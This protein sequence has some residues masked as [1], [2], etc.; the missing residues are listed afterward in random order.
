VQHCPLV[1]VVENNGYAYSTPTRKQ[2]LAAS[3]VDKAIGYGIAAEQADG[4]DVIATYVATKRAVDRA[5]RGEGVTLVELITYRR[6]GHAEH[7]NQS[8][9][10]AGEI[11]RWERENDPL[12]RYVERLV[13]EGVSADVL[14]QLDARVNRELDEATEIAE[15]SGVPEP[16]DALV[17]VYADPPVEQPLWFREGKRAVVDVHERPEG[18]GTFDAPAK[19]AD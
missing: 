14:A 6:K 11:D 1:V 19:G 17:G 12:T 13:A 7:D 15:R 16:L 3:F 18:W 4:N 2:T 5:R 10:P 9:V 8:Y